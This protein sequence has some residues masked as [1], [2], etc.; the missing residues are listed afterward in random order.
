MA[1]P[2]H[3]LSVVR[4]YE[5][6]LSLG[7]GVSEARIALRALSTGRHEWFCLAVDGEE[8]SADIQAE[9]S[10]EFSLTPLALG[11]GAMMV[12]SK[13]TLAPALSSKFL[14]IPLSVR[15]QSGGKM[16]F[17][18]QAARH[19]LLLQI[20]LD[21]LLGDS[22]SLIDLDEAH[23]LVAGERVALPREVVDLLQNSD[24]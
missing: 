15:P 9:V 19:P 17:L 12:A 2:D 10:R 20:G 4:Q 1:L 3:L 8:G 7:V 21:V 13:I 23:R 16:P 11:P 18:Q 24:D 5:T 14:F 6:A 22:L